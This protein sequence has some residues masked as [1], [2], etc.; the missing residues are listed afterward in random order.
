[1]YKDSTRPSRNSSIDSDDYTYAASF[2]T[3]PG[4]DVTLS[5]PISSNLS[6]GP[7]PCSLNTTGIF[8]LAD[9]SNVYIT[10]AS[11]INTYDTTLGIFS[12]GPPSN[13]SGGIQRRRLKT[14]V[15]TIPDAR[16]DSSHSFLF[17]PDASSQY[18]NSF[19]TNYGADYAVSTT[20]MVTQCV[21]ATQ[22]C[23]LV[24]QSSPTNGTISIPFNCSADFNGDL[25]Q[26]PLNGLERVQGWDSGFYANVNGSP[27]TS[28]QAQSNPFYF[29][30]AAAVNSLSFADLKASGDPQAN[31]F[32]VI[33]AGNQ[34]LAFALSCQATIYDVTYSVINGQIIDFTNTT[35]SPQKA[36][37]VKAPLQVGFGR[38]DLYQS[39]LLS[40]LVDDTVANY[41]STAFSQIGIALASGAFTYELNSEQRI[42][43]DLQVTQ[44]PKAPLWFLVSVCLIYILMSLGALVAA[45]ALQRKTTIAETHANLLPTARFRIRKSLRNAWEV[46]KD[47]VGYSGREAQT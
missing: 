2:T 33:D 24:P 20:S 8:N 6:T 19:V 27:N 21:S 18:D 7:F 10:L 5:T 34:R 9:A 17:Y 22:A 36:S 46:A 13:G 47:Q 39:A 1:M 31:D 32:S 30:A 42:R 37:I 38:Y 11:G 16:P 14:Q 25:G 23:H 28:V 41:M 3:V 45:L 29:Y 15:L 43:Y 35:S 12:I 4:C 26:P 40:V 44:V